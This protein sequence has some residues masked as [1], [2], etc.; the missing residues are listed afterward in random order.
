MPPQS[1]QRKN[2]PKNQF[3]AKGDDVGRVELQPRNLPPPH[4]D[5]D[6]RDFNTAFERT[7]IRMSPGEE[8]AI[9]MAWQS[10]GSMQ[11]ATSRMGTVEEA[12][13]QGGLDPALGATGLGHD[14]NILPNP[15]M[16]PIPPLHNYSQLHTEGP[17]PGEVDQG[18]SQP[19]PQE[20]VE[21]QVR[22]R[23]QGQP[24]RHVRP[25]DPRLGEHFPV[26]LPEER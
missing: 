12:F 9:R 6:P 18:F 26:P 19:V 21:H 1:G 3:V 4:R 13:G 15:R 22:T 7:P 17:I 10:P 23:V 20:W 5:P 25:V 8:H 2:N 16:L 24:N 11:E 14:P